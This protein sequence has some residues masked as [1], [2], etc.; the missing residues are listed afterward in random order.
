MFGYI[1]HFVL[2]SYFILVFLLYCSEWHVFHILE[3]VKPTAMGLDGLPEWFIRIAAAAFARPITHLFN[4]SLNFSVVPSQWKSSRISPIP[5]TAQPL[6]SQDY[7]PISIT[8]VLSRLMEKQLV[9]SFLYPIL[10]SPEH[11][12]SFS[13][14][15][16]FRPT[17]ST[18]SALIYLFHQIT[19][20]LQHNEYVHLIALDFSK[21]FDTVR[22]HTLMSKLSTLPVP[23]C[24][25]NW[26]AD[27]L[28]SR[29]HQTKVAENESTFLPISASIIQG[30]GLGPVCYIFNSSDLKP[31]HLTNLLV[32]YAD[33]TY[34]IIPGSNSSLIPD[35]LSN[36]TQWANTNNLKLNPKKSYE[37]IVHLPSKKLTCTPPA[38][39]NIT[40]T[41]QLTVLG[42]TFNNTLSFSPHIQNL[43]A[44]AATT[45]YALKTLKVH[46]LQGKALWEVAR[47]TLVAQITYASPSWSGFIKCDELTRLKAIVSKASRYGYLPADFPSLEQLLDSS[48]ESLFTATRHNPQHVLHQLLPLPKIT[49]YNLRL[50]G[51]GLT[52]PDLQ[53]SY[54]RKNF[55]NRMLYS[56]I[57]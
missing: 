43:T 57:Y 35:E 36:I 16:A 6:T 22:H 19:T 31:V 12:Y 20:L 50:R 47:A 53:S 25:Y 27:Y 1:L 52:L 51:H 24:F 44:K 21:A 49:G 48:D 15:F 42:V 54:M 41:Y 5:K 32:K 46:G 14:Q 56:D 39:D 40:R 8:P 7:R 55:L 45:L 18:T 4:L 9:R 13:D 30:S 3:T 23:D 17:G 38:C 10:S 2:I 34:L 26:L 29:Q 33:D 28:F 11:S 37:M